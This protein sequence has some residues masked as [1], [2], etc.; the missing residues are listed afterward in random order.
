MKPSKELI[1]ISVI[2]LIFGFFLISCSDSV[3]ETDYDEDEKVAAPTFDPPAGNYETE[4]LVTI[5]C[6]TSEATIRYT[7]DGTEPN[8]ESAVYTEP[9][10]VQASVTIKARAYKEGKQASDV[11]SASY[12][13]VIVSAIAIV[14]LDSD[15]PTEQESA[16]YT[17]IT[18][19]GVEPTFIPANAHYENLSEFDLIIAAE[20]E[21]L[22]A[23]TIN[24]LIENGNNVML[25]YSSGTALGGDW[26]SH[27][28]S[29]QNTHTLIVEQNSVFFD[30]YRSNLERSVQQSGT[31]A[32]FVSGIYPAGW[33]IIGRNSNRSENK[34]V[35]YREH[36]SGGKGL[37]F[38]YN[39]ASYNDIG[40]N[41]FDMAFQ[42]LTDIPAQPG[43][44]VPSGNAAFIIRGY[45]YGGTAELTEE[46][47]A[48]YS[49]L[50]HLGYDITFIS[51]SRLANS[52]L[53]AAGLIT[54][55]EY[56]SISSYTIN[57]KIAAGKNVLLMYCSAAPL[58][59][60]WDG[61]S[62]STQGVHRLIIEEDALF[63]DGY[64]SNLSIEI[65]EDSYAYYISEN[66]PAGWSIAGRNTH[67]NR[68]NY[69]TLLYR[70]HGSGGKGLIYT[71]N[72]SSF[73]ETGKNIFEMIYQWFEDEPAHPGKVV[74]DGNV[75]FIIS[76]YVDGSSPDL[77]EAENAHYGNLLNKDYE[78]TF[79]RFS[80]L[81]NSDLS[82]AVMVT[83]ASYPSIDRHTIDEQLSAGNNVFLTYSAAASY[84][85]EWDSSSWDTHRVH[86][87]VV[88][89][90]ADFLVDYEVN[91]S[92][93]VQESGTAFYITSGYP[94]G[95]NILGENGRNRGHKTT[96]SR[97]VNSTKGV[98][99][100]Y[101]PAQYSDAGNEV[102][103]KIIDWLRE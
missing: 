1:L 83:A 79:I 13:I 76:N 53:S 65:L 82:A 12:N 38:T 11:S 15:D 49:N 47:N 77:T 40:R 28:W 71:Y 100:T 3:T 52:D 89:Q 80:R 46:E 66:Y 92:I 73:S 75:A 44:I 84:S 74:P 54:A 17:I 81:K 2:I 64:K 86:I 98:I 26:D 30:G 25:L 94:P 43:V 23:D 91:E 39:P 41:Y 62:W 51:Y 72:P 34:T 16:V 102:F 61:S 63:L 19:F 97:T 37:I 20:N 88:E 42:W 18:D 101:N 103:D 96:F 27:H 57:D 68:D 10:L 9:V 32:F 59:G 93:Q 48:H 99:Y 33:S 85:G 67:P 21:A 55:V 36:G 4:Q 35:L 5:S 90:S 95:W 69:K 24:Y 50:L 45:N 29:T 70:K 87:L 8:E 56:P 31:N 58:G 60:T 78:V 7:I 22:Q 6:E 14:V